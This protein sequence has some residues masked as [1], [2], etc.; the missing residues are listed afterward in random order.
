[1]TTRYL[2]DKALLASTC[3]GCVGSP[4]ALAQVLAGT[5]GPNVVT[6]TYGHALIDRTQAGVGTLFYLRDAQMSTRQLANASGTVTDRYTFDAF[7]VTLA[8]SGSAPNLYLFAGEQ[9]DPNLGFYYLRARYYQQATGRFVTTEPEE[10]SV[11]DPVTL[12]RYLYAGSDPVDHRDPTGRGDFSLPTLT[13]VQ[14]IQASLFAG[15]LTTVGTRASGYAKNWN[16]ALGYGAF[17]S[18]AVLALFL[19]GAVSAATQLAAAQTIRR[20]LLNR[21][22][23][24]LFAGGA[25]VVA[26]E[27]YVFEFAT[28]TFATSVAARCFF[29][30]VVAEAIP[31]AVFVGAVVP[32]IEGYPQPI[33]I[34]KAG[35][36]APIVAN[37]ELMI[38]N[39]KTLL[40]CP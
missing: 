20:S 9:L 6:Y 27:Q 30:N 2:V 15:F 13:V 26:A 40:T 29:L 32:A 31:L 34:L 37:A 7:G 14:T 11:F 3:G 23:H 35:D 36:N 8:A 12:H 39:L 33:Q 18:G 16:E 25:N 24:S 28:K 1:M 5:T 21:L 10:G 17:A 38:Q 22:I 4:G 19:P